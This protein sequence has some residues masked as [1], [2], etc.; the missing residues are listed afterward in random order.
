MLGL[1]EYFP[2]L[3]QG[4]DV[5]G[6]KIVAREVRARFPGQISFVILIASPQLENLML[7]L[8][9]PG[10]DS[11]YPFWLE[12]YGIHPKLEIDA[13]SFYYFNSQ[14]EDHLLNYFSK[15]IPPGGRLFVEY[16]NDLETRDALQRDVPPVLTRLGFRLFELGFLWFKDWYFSEGFWEGTPKLQAEKPLNTELATR[17]KL[18]LK[19][20]VL[21]FL[22]RGRDF[23]EEQFIA[24]K[25]R[26]HKILES[27]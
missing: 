14:V 9:Y 13:Q 23:S 27:L 5:S 19:K 17:Q 10:K 18:K 26:A 22:E 6:Y 3:Q 24:F 12:L 16:L 21:D 8:L 25:K 2:E 1:E 20:E 11:Y 4:L 15:K 7:G